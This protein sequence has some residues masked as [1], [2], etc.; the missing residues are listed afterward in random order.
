[1]ET[2][3]LQAMSWNSSMSGELSAD[4]G[5]RLYLCFRIHGKVRL[6]W[7]LIVVFRVHVNNHKDRIRC[8]SSN[9]LV[10]LCNGTHTS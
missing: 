1:M 3:N 7:D 9:A 10:N 4:R 8:V 6:R 2:T 5:I